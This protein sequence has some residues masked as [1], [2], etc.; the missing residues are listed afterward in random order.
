MRGRQV[1]FRP[2][3]GGWGPERGPVG[4]SQTGGGQG[5]RLNS[6]VTNLGPGRRAGPLS[7]PPPAG[8]ESICPVTA[9]LPPPPPLRRAPLRAVGSPRGIG[10]RRARAGWRWVWLLLLGGLVCGMP[11]GGSAAAQGLDFTGRPIRQIEIIGLEQIASSLVENQLRSAV[12]RPYSNRAAQEDTVRITNLGYFG[13]VTARAVPRDDGGV[14]LQFVVEELPLLTGIEIR[15]NREIAT[16]ELRPLIL[17]RAGDAIDPFPDRPRQAGPD[18]CLR[19]ARPL[20]HRHLDRPG[21]PG[22]RPPAGLP[23]PRGSAYPSAADRFRG[24]HR[25]RGQGAAQGD[26]VGDLGLAPRDTARAQ[27]RRT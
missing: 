11:P 5:F 22:P 19:G 26:P 18:R 25:F 7:A 17:L 1:M 20:R 14:T 4:V 15:G 27:P 10:G 8:P 2:A 21:C 13:S 16:S 24:Q 23:D 3:Q 9:L 6:R 12:G